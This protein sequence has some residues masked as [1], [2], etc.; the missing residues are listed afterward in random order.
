MPS[1]FSII[2][3]KPVS[4][5]DPIYGSDWNLL[6]TAIAK[7]VSELRAITLQSSGD[8]IVRKNNNGSL[9]S[10]RS[11]SRGRGAASEKICPFGEI[12]TW[13]EGEGESGETKTGIRGGIIYCGDKNWNMAAQELTLTETDKWLVW[14]TI[15]CESVR[16]DDN[17]LILPGIK[18]GTRPTGDWDKITIAPS[19]DTDYA[20]NDEPSVSDG[21]G[22]IRVPLG[23]LKIK[24]GVATFAPAGCGN[25]TITQCGGVLGHTRT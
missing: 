25:I 10:L 17:Q 5:G 18:T 12:I 8:I 14:I 11:Q 22:T 1:I 2:L 4:K 23:I 6:I 19:G 9:A 13:T 21:L 3:P 15:V 7:I 20:S 24:S 16:D